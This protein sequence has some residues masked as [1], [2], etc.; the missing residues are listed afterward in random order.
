MASMGPFSICCLM[1]QFLSIR[2]DSSC[3]RTPV[4]YSISPCR[5]VMMRDATLP[6]SR[7]EKDLQI[8]RNATSCSI[9]I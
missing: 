6:R 2:S 1:A 7:M 8:D 5:A 4:A 9:K 3:F